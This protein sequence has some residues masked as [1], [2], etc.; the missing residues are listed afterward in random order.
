MKM[1]FA[2]VMGVVYSEKGFRFGGYTTEG[3]LNVVEPLE[4]KRSGVIQEII[5]E[6]H[7]IFHWLHN[8]PEILFLVGILTYKSLW[9]ASMFFLAAYLIEYARFYMLRSSIIIAHIS[10]LWSRL[11]IIAYLISA[12]YLW[13]Q[14]KILA[15]ILIAFIG[16]QQIYLFSN[17][18]MLPLS[19]F[20][21]SIIFKKYGR[22]WNN[23]FALSLQFAINR[24]RFKLFP[25]D[26]FNVSI[27]IPDVN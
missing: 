7:Y 1:K 25:A 9:I 13:G 21:A 4:S 14:S 17:F 19:T 10:L 8:F 20:L 23:Y 16:L 5:A 12:I 15:I 24:W 22:P 11:R 26:R 27:D 3:F 6:A 18:L 2:D